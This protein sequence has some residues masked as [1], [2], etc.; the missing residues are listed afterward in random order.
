M[1]AGECKLLSQTMKTR[2]HITSFMKAYVF[3]GVITIPFAIQAFA[4]LDALAIMQLVAFVPIIM[5]FILKGGFAKNVKIASVISLLNLGVYYWYVFAMFQAMQQLDS[6][7]GPR[8]EGSPGAA[9]LSG[10]AVGFLVLVPWGLAAFR[11]L[12]H[13]SATKETEPQIA[14]GKTPEASQSPNTS[15]P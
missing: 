15:N 5:P 4:V 10:F 12:T 13:F 8:G 3:A 7:E 1:P 2:C 6:L 14:D 11:G 9:I